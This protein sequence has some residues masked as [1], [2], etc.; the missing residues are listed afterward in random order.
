MGTGS[1]PSPGLTKKLWFDLPP[2]VTRIEET[3]CGWDIKC[4]R[5]H[6]RGNAVVARDHYRRVCLVEV[7]LHK[8]R[9]SI[10]FDQY[11]LSERAYDSMVRQKMEQTCAELGEHCDNYHR[12]WRD[13]KI[14]ELQR[15]LHEVRHHRNIA[16]E[17]MK[18]RGE[19]IQNLETEI[20]ALRAQV[21]E[22]TAKRPASTTFG[23][24]PRKLLV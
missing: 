15:D 4:P 9:Q 21:A 1:M 14:H 10:V 8:H 3:V 13:E 6:A 5:C 23:P 12:D 17:E 2:P 19:R 16:N 11:G 18:L 22:L 7:R 24:Q 20:A